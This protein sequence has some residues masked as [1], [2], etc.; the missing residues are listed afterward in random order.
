MA[1]SACIKLQKV[2]TSGIADHLK[3]KF[4]GACIEPVLLYGSETW[5]VNKDFENRLNGCY[6]RLLMKAKNLS[7]KK[8]PTL[9]QIYGD[10]PRIASV[11]AQRRARF[12]GHCMRASNEI[13]SDILP[14][15]IQQKKRGRRPLTYLDI[16][17][18]DA[19][20]DISDIRT[21][22]MDRDVWKKVVK[23]ISFEDRLK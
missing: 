8:H 13:I 11:V 10:L 14:W 17:S 4:F 2:W 18:R 20:I 19:E 6:T 15:R 1:W 3:V 23:G 7:W 21:A 16:V 12:A 22:M 5:T 9:L